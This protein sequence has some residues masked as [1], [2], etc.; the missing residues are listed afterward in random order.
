[1]KN[2]IHYS[3]KYTADSTSVKF[4]ALVIATTLF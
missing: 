2:N 4:A 3:K 1:M